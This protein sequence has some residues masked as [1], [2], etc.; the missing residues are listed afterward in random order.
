MILGENLEINA[1]YLY[2]RQLWTAIIRVVYHFEDAA[3]QNRLLLKVEVILKKEMVGL[4]FCGG[5]GK[6]RQVDPCKAIIYS[7]NFNGHGT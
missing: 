2:T 5:A 1:L 3:H 6:I 4:S 7:S